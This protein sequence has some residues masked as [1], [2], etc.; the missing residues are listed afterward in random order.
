MPCLLDFVAPPGAPLA[1]RRW[2]RRLLLLPPAPSVGRAL[3]GACRELGALAE[4]LPSFPTMSAANVV[5][6]LRSR[7]AN[8]TFFREVRMCA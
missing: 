3:H 5:L 8:D 1:A 6:K 4:A 2:L 7:E